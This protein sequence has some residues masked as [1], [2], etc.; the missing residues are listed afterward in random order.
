ML[1]DR[2]HPGRAAGP[3]MGQGSGVSLCFPQRCTG[4]I[5]VA[6]MGTVQVV[7]GLSTQRMSGEDT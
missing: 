2:G 5:A 4:R 3:E 7:P 1:S 6:E